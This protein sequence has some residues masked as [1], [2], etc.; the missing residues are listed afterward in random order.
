MSWKIGA[1]ALLMVASNAWAAGSQE[2]S[3]EMTRMDVASQTPFVQQRSRIEA[4]FAAGKYSEITK[5]DSD[6]VYSALG[7]MSAMLM[8]VSG[9]A[10]LS[11]D[12]KVKLFNDQELVNTLLTK[13]G[14]DS[15]LVCT[16]ERATGSHRTTNNCMTVAE[17]RRLRDKSQDDLRARQRGLLPARN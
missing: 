12:D 3:D 14:D 5:A 17:R 9:P 2:K 8:D 16:R 15:R 4:D 10:E 7:R 1:M 13:A 6:E 11:E